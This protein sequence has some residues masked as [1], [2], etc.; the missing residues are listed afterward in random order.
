MSRTG[1]YPGSFDPVTY[2]HLDI[3]ER[4]LH[5]FDKV[6]LA[7]ADNPFKKSMFT[8]A[9]RTSMLRE[10]TRDMDGVEVASFQILTVEY[11]RK[12]NAVAIIRGLRAMSDF[13]YEFQM[14]LTNRAL[15]PEIEIIYMMPQQPYTFVS[16]TMAKELTMFDGDIDQFVPPCVADTL[17]KKADEIRRLHE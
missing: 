13:E 4:A 2:G 14:A 15:A 7:V 3:V 8:A 12:M 1:L 5:V 11:A 16:S 17:R 9:E 10:A 6:I